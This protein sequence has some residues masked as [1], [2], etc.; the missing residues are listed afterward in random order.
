MPAVRVD[1]QHVRLL[2][3]IDRPHH[4][5]KGHVD[6]RDGVRRAAV[7]DV[8]SPAGR[9]VADAIG[10]SDAIP[11]AQHAAAAQ[12]QDLVGTMRGQEDLIR[13]RIARRQHRR[14]AAN[15]GQRRRHSQRRRIEDRHAVAAVVGDI[16]GAALHYHAVGHRSRWDRP[17]Y[18]AQLRIDDAGIAGLTIGDHHVTAGRDHRY[19]VGTGG[20]RRQVDLRSQT[21]IFVDDAQG[22]AAVIDAVEGNIGPVAGRVERDAV[23]AAAGRQVKLARPIWGRNSTRCRGRYHIRGR[24]RCR[25]ER[26]CNARM[27][28]RA[29]SCCHRRRGSWRRAAAQDQRE[30]ETALCLFTLQTNFQRGRIRRTCRC[31]RPY[32]C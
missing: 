13:P 21:E 14:L 16:A 32:R 18:R 29:G 31:G 4:G 30:V 23:R 25:C 24:S 19:A 8:Q 10:R 28:G 6:H 11:V 20:A 2:A 1:E 26:G 7:G 15:A 3:D 22:V 12:V 9:I 27:Q 17:N 5:V